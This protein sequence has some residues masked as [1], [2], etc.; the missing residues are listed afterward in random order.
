MQKKKVLL[1]ACAV[2]LVCVS[3]ISGVT[4]A[5]FTESRTVNAHL[6][7]GKLD[8]ALTRTNLE[9]AVLNDDGVLEVKTDDTDVDFTATTDGCV[10]GLDDDDV[11]IV[12]GS[13]F[14][15]DMLI[16][17]LGDAAFT[18]SIKLVLGQ[19][20]DQKLASQLKVSLLNGEEVLEE[21]LLSELA[22]N[23]FVLA[24][25]EMKKSD[26]SRAFTV[27]VAFVEDEQNNAAQQQNAYFDLIVSAEQKTANDGE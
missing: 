24:S 27:K 12:P 16:D 11:K 4:Y 20:S 14:K 21:K 8:I 3:I 25:G 13:Y 19:Q 17:N 26:A 23:G 22:D 6:Q 7:A 1:V 9:Y 18:Y 2:I 15:A 10:F 5:L